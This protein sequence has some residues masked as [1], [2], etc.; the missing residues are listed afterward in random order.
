MLGA[1]GALVLLAAAAADLA[2]AKYALPVGCAA[3]LLCARP[4]LPGWL[5]PGRG[6]ELAGAVGL[7]AGAIATTP[8]LSPSA[9]AQPL[10][11]DTARWACAA[12]ALEARGVTHVA[13]DYW[14]AKPLF[15]GAAAAGVDLNI[16]QI[17]LPANRPDTWIA[18]Y[19][20]VGPRSETLVLDRARCA[21]IPLP[22]HCR[23]DFPSLP[24]ARS[25]RQV[26]EGIEIA[27]L[28]RP[29]PEAE[30]AAAA[31]AQVTGKP[32]SLVYNIRQNVLKALGRLER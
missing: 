26:C 28:A 30:A 14:D 7:V 18:P 32:G 21:R 1:A 10:R 29:V 31:A 15:L 24:E 16:A 13:A 23:L 12:R 5:A 8:A 19:A 11:A 6:A 27:V 25:A 3:L 22:G 17:D 4:L 9:A 20:F 2:P